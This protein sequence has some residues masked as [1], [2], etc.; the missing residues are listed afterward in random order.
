[1]SIDSIEKMTGIDFFHK[2]PDEVE[3]VVESEYN[4]N[5]WR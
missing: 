5:V 3:D 1:M 2:L 4:W